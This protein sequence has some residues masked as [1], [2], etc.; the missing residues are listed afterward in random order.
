MC[1]SYWRQK[2]VHGSQMVCLSELQ[3]HKTLILYRC[4]LRTGLFELYCKHNSGWW[5]IMTELEVLVHCDS[6][7]TFC[8]TVFTRNKLTQ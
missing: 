3:P 1:E 6:V 2:G 7:L 4:L 5:V 8:V